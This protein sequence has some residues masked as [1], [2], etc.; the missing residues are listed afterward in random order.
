M[1]VLISALAYF[2]DDYLIKIGGVEGK[3]H[4]QIA[5]LD[6]VGVSSFP[7]ISFKI[8]FF[9][10]DILNR[11]FPSA[12]AITM[13][14]IL[15]VFS[16]SRT[17]ASASGQ[18]IN[19]NQEVFSFGLSNTFLSFLWGAMPASGSISRSLFNFKSK[20]RTRF[21][22]VFSGIF[23]ALLIALFWSFVRHIPL[24]ALSSILIA[25]APTFID[26][27]QVKLCFTVTKED[28]IVFLLT[29]F[30]CLIFTLHIAL[31][32]GIAIS[33]ATYLRRAA[34]PHVV[35]YAF[36]TAGRLVIVS[37]KKIVRRSIR[38]IGIAGELFF[39][40]ADI[41]Q[42]T[43]QKAAKDPFV[44]VIVLRL[45]NVY[46]ID[47]SMCQALV[48]LYEYLKKSNKTLIISGITPEI[49]QVFSTAGLVKQIGEDN[50]FITDETNPQLSTWNA[51]MRAK[52]LLHKF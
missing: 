30:S 23:V 19:P 20:G 17:V 10:L 41:F 51:C 16:V 50:L 34:V 8:P 46:H 48:N 1:L 4:F 22:A 45:N 32:I 40:M 43:F 5:F 26:Y 2:F 47:A 29:I 44:K 15:E 36:N 35:E 31:F 9:N 3:P 13:L 24:V 11:I 49:W 33:I 14:G 12:L 6:D 39:G 38:I 27:R 37:Q 18:I 7:S 42:N 21:S 52:D 25:M 28:R